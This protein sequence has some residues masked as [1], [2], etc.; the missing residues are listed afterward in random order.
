[1]RLKTQKLPVFTVLNAAL[2]KAQKQAEAYMYAEYTELRKSI[3]YQTVV[4]SHLKK[5]NVKKAIETADTE[6]DEFK[7]L[8]GILR[9]Q[10]PPK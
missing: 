4:D 3:Q 2:R 1:M 6:E 9:L 10:N 5:G 8:E 7:K